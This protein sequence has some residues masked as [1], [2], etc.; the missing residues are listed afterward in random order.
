LFQPR[1]LFD[2]VALEG[3]GRRGLICVAKNWSQAVQ[4]ELGVSGATEQYATAQN[5]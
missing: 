4:G 3:A 2:V 1:L 5:P